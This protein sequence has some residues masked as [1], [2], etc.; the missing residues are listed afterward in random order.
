MKQRHM[1][2]N[3][4][5]QKAGSKKI[6]KYY[7]DC[8]VELGRA[9]PNIV[10]LS[11]DLAPATECDEF[12]KEFPKRYFSA[13]IAE[14]NMIG[15]AAGMARN[16]D[17]PFVHSFSV[18]LS[19]RAYDQIAMQIAYPKLNVKLAGF[20]PG[21]TTNLGVSHQAID[22]IALM[23]ALPSM[24]IVEPGFN[25]QIKQL[26]VASA[27][28]NG[29]VYMR[30]HRPVIFDEAFPYPTDFEIGKGQLLINGDDAIVFASG[31]SVR[32]AILASRACA[33]KGVSVAVANIHTIKPLDE[34]FLLEQIK[35]KK[36]AVTVENHSII[37]GL[38]AAI[39]EVFAESQNVFNR[40]LKFKR[41]G[42]NDKF[43]EG[44]STEFLFAKYGL[45]SIHIENT[46]ISLIENSSDE[47]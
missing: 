30:L 5:T 21:L 13:G 10:A 15:L 42:V 18:F 1:H 38:G 11:G 41:I 17:T 26:V 3:D 2:L 35:D 22:D 40:N 27:N 28:F 33:E 24:T 43:A 25:S 9:N 4:F 31:H 19:R 32:E 8:L 45:S 6:P 47:V 14:A 34:L 23:R 20:L 39:A 12:K 16:G 29:P 37:G 36:V 44:G 46:I 7:G